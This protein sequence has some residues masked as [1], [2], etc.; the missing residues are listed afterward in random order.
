MR[1]DISYV[2][3]DTLNYELSVHALARSLEQFPLENIL[4]FS[5]IRVDGQATE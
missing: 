5:E 2:V 3:I 1:Q 4:I